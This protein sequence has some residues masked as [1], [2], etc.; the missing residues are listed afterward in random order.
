M[1]ESEVNAAEVLRYARRLQKTDNSSTIYINRDLAPSEAK[2]AYD[3]PV[4]RREKNKKKEEKK[5]KDDDDE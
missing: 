4:R 5:Q 3:E 1:L 2:A